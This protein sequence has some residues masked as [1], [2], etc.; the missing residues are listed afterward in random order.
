V[1]RGDGAARPEATMAQ[2]KATVRCGRRRQWRNTRRGGG[3]VSRGGS[4]S[5]SRGCGGREEAR[6][7]PERR[8]M[9]GSGRTS[10]RRM[11]DVGPASGSKAL[12][13]AGRRAAW[14]D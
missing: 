3:S 14:W 6:G 13:M 1:S 12:L 5:V 2:A 4:G 8:K 7:A 9:E 11:L 10:D